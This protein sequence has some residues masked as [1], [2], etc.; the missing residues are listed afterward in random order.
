MLALLV[1][2]MVTAGDPQPAWMTWF[3]DVAPGLSKSEVPPAPPKDWVSARTP[4]N[5]PFRLPPDYHPRNSSGCWTKE[6]PRL[7]G[8]GYRDVCVRRDND[9]LRF[10]GFY[11]K[12]LRTNPRATDQIQF[13][14]WRAETFEFGG[15]RVVV[16]HALKSGGFAGHRRVRS[17]VAF[18]ELGGHE[19]AI[20]DGATGDDEGY[21]ELLTIATTIQPPHLLVENE[22][23]ALAEDYVRKNGFVDAADAA[24]RWAAQEHELH[25]E[26]SVE[27]LISRRAHDLL[28]LACGVQRKIR[29]GFQWAWHVVFCYDPRK[30]RATAGVERVVQVDVVG[31]DPFIPESVP[32]NT[33]MQSQ[34]LKRLQGVFEFERLMAASRRTSR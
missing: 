7:R 2:P 28:P 19:L 10:W 30:P 34:G 24:P 12:P 13:E 11:L 26:N 32:D 4:D 9:P 16:E 22:A 1:A 17:M 29:G 23:V 27:E 15:R 25:P 31:S 33:S 18:V 14:D 21:R 3:K 20:V 8:P 6:S 5:L